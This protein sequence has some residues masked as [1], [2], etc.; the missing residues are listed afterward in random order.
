MSQSRLQVITPATDVA[1]L[2]ATE[3]RVAAGLAEA[4]AT[5]DTALASLGLEAAEWIADILGIRSAGGR[6][7]T[8]IAEVVRETFAPAWRGYELVLARRFV[9]DVT[10]TE[11]GGVLVEDTDFVV[12]DDR[13][14]LERVSSGYQTG[15]AVG[16]IV[17]DYTTGFANGSP[18]LV[19][20]TIKAVAADY[21]ALRYS[22]AGRDPMVRSET[23]NDL[24][25]VTYRDGSDSQGSF[26]EAA[27]ERLSRYIAGTA[28]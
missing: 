27:R 8:V 18:S 4:D 7:P 24:D 12:Y 25:S 20:P 19:P 21:V 6:V 3:L 5:H 2:T 17:V 9:S 23:T 26:E 28:G 14:M 11:S 13:G 15:W 10:V 16:P 22:A 1:L